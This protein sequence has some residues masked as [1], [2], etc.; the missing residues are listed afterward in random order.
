[1]S[2]FRTLLIF[3]TL[4]LSSQPLYSQVKGTIV[5][6]GAE[7]YPIAVSPLKNLG[8]GEDAAR[9]SEGIGISLFAIWISRAGSVYWTGPHI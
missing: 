7:R 6:P 3:F 1:M 9:L 8:Q 4:W 5:G 2:V